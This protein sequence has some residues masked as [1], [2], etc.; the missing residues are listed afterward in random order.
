MAVVEFAKD[1][2]GLKDASSNEFSDRTK[3]PVIHIMDSQKDIY[4]KGGTMRLGAYVSKIKK[5][6]LTEKIYGT[7][8]ISERHRHRYEFNNAYRTIMQNAGMVISGTSPD[9]TLVEMIEIPQNKFFIGCQ[10]HPE[11]K[12]RP[13]K[14]APLFKAFIKAAL[15]NKEMERKRGNEND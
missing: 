5:G 10:F 3:N 6:T 9:D 1:V 11:F 7:C 2:I 15:E 14:P 8:Q 4:K 13:N 12:S